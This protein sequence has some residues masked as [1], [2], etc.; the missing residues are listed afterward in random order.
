MARIKI[1]KCA[2]VHHL[3]V[4]N[5]SQS[6]DIPV[7]G[8]FHDIHDDL[9]GVLTD[10]SVEF[11]IENAAASGGIAAAGGA[12]GLGGS[13]ASSPRKRNRPKA[14]KKPKASKPKAAKAK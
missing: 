1:L 9:L 5:G 7:D 14:A 2:E 6:A 4:T 3:P 13:A 8:A 10:S 11:E 12:A